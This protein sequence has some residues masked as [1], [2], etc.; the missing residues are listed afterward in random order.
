MDDWTVSRRMTAMRGGTEVVSNP[1]RDDG[2]QA[3][4]QIGSP[5]EWPEE[6]ILCALNGRRNGISGVD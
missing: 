6:E 4:L 3:K 5:T 1:F 2:D